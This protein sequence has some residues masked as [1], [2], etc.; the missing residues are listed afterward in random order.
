[1]MD[2]TVLI[3]AV[4]LCVDMM[5]AIALNLITLGDGT[6]MIGETEIEHCPWC[7]RK[8]VNWEHLAMGYFAQGYFGEIEGEKLEGEKD[9]RSEKIME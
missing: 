1:M 2:E 9:G 6:Y 3:K 5:G 7:G 4:S 8:L